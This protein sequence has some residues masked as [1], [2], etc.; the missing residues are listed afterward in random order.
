MTDKIVDIYLD[1]ISP[2]WKRECT[3]S[4]KIKVFSPYITSPI[5]DNIIA[6][7]S[8]RHC[9]IYTSFSA[10]LFV[11]GASSLNTLRKL[12]DKGFTLYHLPD[13]HAKIV[14]VSGKFV[15]IGS[16]NL[17]YGGTTNLESSVALTD[18]GSIKDVEEK[19]DEWINNRHE[20]TTQ[21]LIDM[22]E[23]IE[24]L[25]TPYQ[26]LHRKA[27]LI[28]KKLADQERDRKEKLEQDRLH[29]EK[30][31]V[32]KCTEIINRLIN[33]RPWLKGDEVVPKQLCTNFI[34]KSAWW[35]HPSGG[36]VRAPGHAERIKQD[37]FH[38]WV[39]EFGANTFLVG[40]AISR[41]LKIVLSF[42][43]D[44][45]HNKATNLD[46]L[47][48]TIKQRISGA[49]AGYSGDE[50]YEYP[51][52]GQDLTFGTQSIDVNDGAKYILKITGVQ[53]LIDKGLIA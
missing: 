41:S 19:L 34:Q 11:S 26:D 1:D 36:F 40:K 33:D 9:E 53:S 3:S 27:E 45:L 21:M 43:S 29:A 24:P 49:V 5:V 35:D 51:I 20:I 46:K 47:N 7:V 4:K 10:W 18:F 25:L 48:R 31:R 6:D 28:D 23:L 50:Y 14:L 32:E 37:T 12:K 13:L 42:Y 30:E 22:D 44:I 52:D 17:T 8:R 16:Q 15:S 38:G 39:I 2:R